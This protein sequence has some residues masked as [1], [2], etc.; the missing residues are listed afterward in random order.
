MPILKRK[1][2]K[3]PKEDNEV[4]QDFVDLTTMDFPEESGCAGASAIIKVAEI[5]RYEDLGQVTNHI[6]NGNI[7]LLDYTAVSQDSLTLKRITNELKSITKDTNGDM[8]GIGKNMLIVTPK[9]IKI[10]RNKIKPSY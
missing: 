8:A 2:S 1:V 3:K 5:G 6:Y 9:G 7:L 10:D 4:P